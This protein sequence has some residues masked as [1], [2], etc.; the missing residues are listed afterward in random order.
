LVL[1]DH[2]IYHDSLEMNGFM[3]AYFSYFV[4]AIQQKL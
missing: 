1:I 4:N 2:G 3:I